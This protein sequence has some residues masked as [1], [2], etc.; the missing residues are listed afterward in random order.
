MS[1]QFS[2]NIIVL[3]ARLM[4][5]LLGRQIELS[6]HKEGELA[7]RLD[8]LFLI[9]NTPI[10]QKIQKIKNPCHRHSKHKVNLEDLFRRSRGA[11]TSMAITM[12]KETR[13]F[14]FC[15]LP[16]RL[17][18]VSLGAA[19]YRSKR[20]RVRGIGEVLAHMSESTAYANLETEKKCNK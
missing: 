14:S 3:A 5:T 8:R 20:Q 12:P 2:S 13:Y 6:M 11:S 16:R 1:S 18:T 7:R 15:C 10:N 17:F 4:A 9:L 19:Q